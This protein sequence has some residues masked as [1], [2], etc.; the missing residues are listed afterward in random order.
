MVTDK[1]RKVNMGQISTLLI[2]KDLFE[3]VCVLE[4]GG[5]GRGR[6]RKRKRESQADSPLSQRPM[7]GSISHP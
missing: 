7:Q 2:L 4:S 6:E 5:R 1:I 3:R